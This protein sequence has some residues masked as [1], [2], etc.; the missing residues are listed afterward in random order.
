MSRR[1][2]IATGIG[3]AFLLLYAL[4]CCR[5]IYLGDSGE[6]VTAASNLAI[7]HPPGYPLYCLLGRLFTIVPVGSVALRMNLFS[8]LFGAISVALLYSLASRLTGDTA[9]ALAASF[10][11][12]ATLLWS[13]SAAA[14]V[15]TLHLVILLLSIQCLTINDSKKA[16]CA[17]AYMTSLA[18]LSHPTSLILIPL[19]AYRAFRTRGVL[20]PMAALF[21]A[22][23]S[24]VLYLPIRSA[25]DPI[26]DWGNPETPR[27]L[28]AHLFRLQ[29]ANV[30]QPERTLLF[31]LRELRSM[32]DVLFMR[33]LSPLLLPLLPVGL[34][35]LLRSRPRPGF[36]LLLGIA[37]LFPVL[38]LFLAFPLAPERIEENSVFFLPALAL[39]HLLLATGIGA[40]IACAGEKKAIRLIIVSAL[41]LLLLIR[42]GT[43]LPAHRYDRVRLPDFYA[44]Q[45]LEKL[46]REAYIEVVGDDLVFPLLYLREVEGVRNDLL[47]HNPN[48]TIYKTIKGDLPPTSLRYSS[49]PQ[50]G[51]TPRGLAYSPPDN[52]N[53]SIEL[54]LSL[55]PERSW[56]VIVS[57]EHLS[58]LWINYEETQALAG[59]AGSAHLDRAA[60]HRLRA[61][62]LSSSSLVLNGDQGLAYAKASLLADRSDWEGAMEVLQSS[63]SS[64]AEDAHTRLLLAEM[65][66]AT[67]R[68]EEAIAL[69]D[70][71]DHASADLLVRGG[72]TL[73]LAGRVDR[74]AAL[75]QRAASMERD[76][77]VPLEYLQRLEER[78]KEWGNMLSLGRKALEIDPLLAGV[79][80]RV[81]RALDKI[82]RKEEAL[83]EY[84]RL[85][86]H[87]PQGEEAM[88][89]GQW[90]AENKLPLPTSSGR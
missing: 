53:G 14:E 64:G 40:A 73:L 76:N 87:S 49:F 21:F 11:G 27:A 70:P 1:I 88:E 56:D 3:L 28:A 81:A 35:V 38:V 4:T 36:G 66:L 2:Q 5:T 50:K 42:F 16:A 47:I 37:I 44:R 20:L 55:N 7:P 45:L 60:T 9:A 63:I 71:G 46:P 74:G 86:L 62:R 68:Y 72:T 89:A 54:D 10:F 12:L 31:F 57:S 15:Y 80:L 32:S 58:S 19:V 13:Q 51:F 17:G 84:R 41:T 69:A 78:R 52:R 65:L 75:M 83:E 39:I 82:G 59:A 29:Y 22:G 48:G 18:I 6:L 67:G 90:F 30:L 24:I 25:L 34:F 23:L 61:L 33:N 77:P 79:R 8:A 26:P 43:Q 85:F